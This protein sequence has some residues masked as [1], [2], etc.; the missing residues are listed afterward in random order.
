MAA[1][2]PSD[3]VHAAARLVSALS[4]PEVGVWGRAAILGSLPPPP[5]AGTCWEVRSG[6]CCN[7]A[8]SLLPQL[9][10]LLLPSAPMSLLPVPTGLQCHGRPGPSGHRDQ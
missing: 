7:L 9:M 4:V 6:G 8:W 10:W 3:A 2:C 5:V 1:L